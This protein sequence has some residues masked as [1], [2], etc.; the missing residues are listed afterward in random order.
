MGQVVQLDVIMGRQQ[1]QKSNAIVGRRV[2]GNV[3][4]NALN[5]S[6]RGS[7]HKIQS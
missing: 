6:K 4:E 3:Q 7:Q 1:F 5:Q 2:N